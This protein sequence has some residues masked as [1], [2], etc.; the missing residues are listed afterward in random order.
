MEIPKEEFARL[1]AESYNQGFKMAVTVLTELQKEPIR[2]E[3]LVRLM[4]EA[5]I[6]E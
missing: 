2:P 5:G 4:K 1:L 6:N 3:S